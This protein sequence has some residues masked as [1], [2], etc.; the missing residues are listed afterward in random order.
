M[1]KNILQ[2]V[3]TIFP[4]IFRKDKI[5]VNSPFLKITTNYVK[6]AHKMTL[7]DHLC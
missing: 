3:E 5:G 2:Q 6:F 1:E 7:L 4:M